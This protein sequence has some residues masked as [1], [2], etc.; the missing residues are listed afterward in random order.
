M[1]QRTISA[2]FILAITITCVLIGG[3]AMAAICCFIDLWASKEV[4]DLKKDSKLV[5]KQSNKKYLSLYLI[6][7]LSTL[8]ISFGPFVFSIDIQRLVII[9]E[10][11]VLCTMVVFTNELEFKDATLIFM[12]S[13][14]IGLGTYYFMYFEEFS[15]FLFA[16]VILI[17]YLC[18]ASAYIIGSLFGKH[19]LNERI[20][21]KKTIEGSIGG[22][23]VTSIVSFIFAYLFKFFYMD[24]IVIVISSLTLPL[25]SEIG[26]LVFSMIKRSYMIKDF[27]NLIPGHGGILD[28][29]DSLLFVTLFLGVICL[30]IV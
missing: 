16:Y 9:V 5:F 17:C 28:R 11:L 25:I 10:P 2:V 23:I 15:K 29:L 3:Y 30:F 8:L 7:A 24:I 19:K 26:D 18:D 21:P 6:M 13:I 22:W 14:I 20:S 4:I 12:M 1:K 27:S